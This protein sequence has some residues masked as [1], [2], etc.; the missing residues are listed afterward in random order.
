MEGHGQIISLFFPWASS[1][2]LSYKLTM[3]VWGS[4]GGGDIMGLQATWICLLLVSN[5]AR[6][7]L[8]F[9]YISLHIIL[10]PQNNLVKVPKLHHLQQLLSQ[11]RF[12][13]WWRLMKTWDSQ[14]DSNSCQRWSWDYN[15]SLTPKFIFLSWIQTTNSQ[16]VTRSQ[17]LRQTRENRQNI[18]I[19]LIVPAV[20]CILE[21]GQKLRK[22]CPPTIGKM[23]K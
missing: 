1:S 9:I 21:A 16:Q 15:V 3:G 19:F 7:F 12:P 14:V 11:P 8:C 23:I 6:L 2:W 20:A 17:L 10:S 13:C 18:L 4:R 22:I 5:K